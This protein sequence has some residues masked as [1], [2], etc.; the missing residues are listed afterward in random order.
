MWKVSGEKPRTVLAGKSLV[1]EFNDMEPV[2]YDRPL[3]E[4]RVEVYRRI[5]KAGEFRP[6]TWASVLCQETNCVYRVNGKHTAHMLAGMDPLPEFYVTV[7]RYVC[8]TLQDAA[9]LYNTFDSKMASRSTND[10][11]WAFAATIPDLK[12]CPKRLINLT[13]GAAA[14]RR[15]GEKAKDVP[16]AERAE[17]LMDSYPFALWLHTIITSTSGAPGPSRHLVKQPVV[18]AM[19]ATY[20]RLPNKSAEFWAAVRDESAPDRDD[21]TRVLARYLVRS[22]LAGGSTSRVGEGKKLTDQREM[23]VKCLHAWNAWRR[24]EATSLQYYAKAPLPDV[25]R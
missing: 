12:D 18:N 13:V 5:L 9:N 20:D 8:D 25:C 23:Y 21:P 4:R 6:V 16:P 1:R 15:W 10:I 11:N 14:F 17:E 24:G 22:A 2:P 3:S 7:E 19:L